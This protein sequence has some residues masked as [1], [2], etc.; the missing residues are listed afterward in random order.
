[1]S[2]LLLTITLRFTCDERKISSTIKKSQNIMNMIVGWKF[3]KGVQNVFKNVEDNIKKGWC[4][5]LRVPQLYSKANK[6]D[7]FYVM[8]TLVWTGKVDARLRYWIFIFMLPLPFFENQ[9]KYPNF[10][11]KCPDCSHLW[12]EF[13]ICNA[14]LRIPGRKN[15]KIL[16]WGP[17]LYVFCMKCLSKYPYYKKPTLT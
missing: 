12:V 16:P 11:K 17:F 15:S 5:R 10:G 13:L 7:G 4:L 9:T 8:V 14:F 1:M 6:R 3:G 2:C